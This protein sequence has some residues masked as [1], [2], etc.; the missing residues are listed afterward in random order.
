MLTLISRRSLLLFIVTPILCS[1]FIFTSCTPAG[2][3]RADLKKYF[4][5]YEV[6]GCFELFDL[7]KSQFY[8][9]RKLLLAYGVDISIPNNVQT[10]PIKIKTIEL[11]AL[12]APDWYIKKYA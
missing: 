11:A 4:D 5:Q 6:E 8:K 1:L 3:H 9:H 10:L 2:N 7:K 12:T